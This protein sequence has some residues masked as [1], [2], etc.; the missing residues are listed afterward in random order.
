MC[1]S[2]KLASLHH[3]YESWLE[4]KSIVS[5]IDRWSSMDVGH[6]W[7]RELTEGLVSQGFEN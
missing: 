6:S 2:T 3:V 5:D 4:L 1:L 7:S